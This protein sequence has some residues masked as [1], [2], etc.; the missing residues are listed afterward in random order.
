MVMRQ[1]LG[2]LQTPGGALYMG[3]D[4]SGHPGSLSPETHMADLDR[5]GAQA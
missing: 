4:A 1:F 2:A 5:A 3:D